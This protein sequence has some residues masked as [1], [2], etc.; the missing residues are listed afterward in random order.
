MGFAPKTD[1]PASGW[2]NP[3]GSCLLHR[4]VLFELLLRLVGCCYLWVWLLFFFFFL[5][6]CFFFSYDFSLIKH[7][8]M[9]LNINSNGRAVLYRTGGLLQWK[10]VSLN[11]VMKERD[12]IGCGYKRAEDQ[13][14]R[15]MV[16]FT[17]NGERLAEG[18]DGVQ[19]GLWPVLHI[20]KKVT[21]R[22][23]LTI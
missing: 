1:Q 18:V 11:I 8:L 23:P 2:V 22:N 5:L 7:G 9:V 10:T 17:C 12:V 21:H 16:Y 4:F 15:G 13:A 14:D 20:Q 6:F 3:V 19:S